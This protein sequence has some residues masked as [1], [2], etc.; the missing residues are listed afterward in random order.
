VA[1]C[2]RADGSNVADQS[3]VL[4]G[5]IRIPNRAPAR[6]A[7]VSVFVFAEDR[8]P[9]EWS[10]TDNEEASS[11]AVLGPCRYIVSASCGGEAAARRIVS[12]PN[13]ALVPNVVV[14]AR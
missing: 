8:T 3:P 7:V 14:G 6:N 4:A 1:R 12:F 5:S 9:A 2:G 11:I 13:T 10:R